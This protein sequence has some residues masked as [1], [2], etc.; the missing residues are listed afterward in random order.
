LRSPSSSGRDGTGRF[1]GAAQETAPTPPATSESFE[2]I[3][4]VVW[5]DPGPYAISG[6]ARHTLTLR[7]GTALQLELQ[8]RESFALRNFGRRVRLLGRRHGANRSARSANIA[9]DAIAPASGIVTLTEPAGPAGAA[10]AAPV[11]GT[12]KVL[13]L[14]L[15]Y[16]DIRRCRIR[17]SSMTT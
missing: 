3:L 9:V 7:E 16:A 1:G 13:Y 6:A 11:I 8:G 2:G 17:L 12:K 14:L 15:R 5:G 4:G 10:L